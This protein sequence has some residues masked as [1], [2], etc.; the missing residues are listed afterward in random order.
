MF[1]SILTAI[2]LTVTASVSSAGV[3]YNPT[4][5]SLTVTGQTTNSQATK[6]YR[7]MKTHDVLSV[8]LSG[9]GGNYYAGLRLGRLIR[10]EGS[11]VIIPVDTLCVSAC[12]FAALGSDRVIVDGQLW[13][14]A[15]YLTAVPTSASILE[16]TQMFGRAY[17]DMASY[18]ISVDVPVNFAHDILVRTTTS[19]FIV[20]DDGLQIDRIRSTEALWGKVIYEYSYATSGGQ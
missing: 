14:H 13:F 1:K 18:L 4:S 15:P 3:V 19:K 2:I 20:I 6:V 8:S 11:T 7:Y 16:I 10:A 5:K 9:P 17:L 12:A